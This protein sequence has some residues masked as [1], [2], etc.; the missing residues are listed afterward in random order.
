MPIR[1]RGKSWQVDVRN[2]DG[3]R[4]R[5]SYA[6]EEEARAAEAALTP[7]PNARA[8]ARKLR[9]RA[10][11]RS[12][13]SRPTSAAP[14]T[15][16]ALIS[17]PPKSPPPTLPESPHPGESSATEADA[18][19]TASSGARYARSGLEP[20]PYSQFQKPL[21]HGR[22]KP[23]CPTPSSKPFTETPAQPCNSLFSSQEKQGS[24]AAQS[25]ASA[26]PTA[27]SAGD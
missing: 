2:T 3:T 1:K 25:N 10:S 6:T 23:P 22:E 11:A 8:E 20:R 5:A 21:L 15:K 26:Q 16:V 4:V 14:S 13:T 19:G 27:T 18:T 7:N 12:R 9:R 17:D 24:D